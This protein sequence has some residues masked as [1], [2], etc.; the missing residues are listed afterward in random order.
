MHRLIAMSLLLA[1]VGCDEQKSGEQKKQTKPVAVAPIPKQTKPVAAPSKDQKTVAAP[2][3][4]EK[5]EPVCAAHT[6]IQVYKN[7]VNG[8]Q[9]YKG[10]LLKVTGSVSIVERRIDRS[11]RKLASL[12][13][14]VNLPMSVYCFFEAKDE[15]PLA[16]LVRFDEVT[17]VGRCDGRDGS[18]I[19][20]SSCRIVQ[21]EYPSQ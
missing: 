2:T 13:F 10:K 17:I 8:D 16:K 4:D 9:E 11:G 15:G 1:L 3:K 14:H 6:V 19:T 21:T 20:L 7:E 12:L 5:I 18:R